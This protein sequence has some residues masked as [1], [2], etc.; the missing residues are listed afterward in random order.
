[1]KTSNKIVWGSLTGLL[2]ITTVFLIVLKVLLSPNL[3][4]NDVADKKE[5]YA[6]REIAMAGFTGIDLDG[7]WHAEI[8]QGPK[9]QI[10]VEGPED[11]L[12]T[13]LADQRGEFL[14]LKMIRQGKDARKL[15]VAITTPV[16]YRLVA[17]GVS[18][19]TLS[20]LQS[21]R[22]FIRTEG[23][24]SSSGKKVKSGIFV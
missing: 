11:L 21:E 19:I 13:L 14:V 17:K 3:E 24:V 4:A 2:G 1:M 10:V 6:S 7:L 22:I 16:L 18:D 15:N 23:V 9:E 5:A 12:K 8:L 20:R